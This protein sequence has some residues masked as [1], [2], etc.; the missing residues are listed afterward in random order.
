MP[1]LSFPVII[2]RATGRGEGSLNV[3]AWQQVGDGAPEGRAGRGL[4]WGAGV[5]GTQGLGWG[6]YQGPPTLVSPPST[7]TFSQQPSPAML[8]PLPTTPSF[9]PG[10]LDNVHRRT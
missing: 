1:L 10:T 8:S 2:I 7:P 6:P 5:A 4:G 9:S 3:E